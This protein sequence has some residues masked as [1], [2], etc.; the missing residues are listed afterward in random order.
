MAQPRPEKTLADYV[1]VAGSPLLIML[2]GIVWWAANKLVWDCTLIDDKQVRQGRVCC[3]R[4]G[5]RVN[6]AVR[7]LRRNRKR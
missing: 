4:R 1:A 6:R 2:L 7:T 3:R 5:W